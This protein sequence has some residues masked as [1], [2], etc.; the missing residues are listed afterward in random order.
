M[1]LSKFEYSENLDQI[2]AKPIPEDS[3]YELEREVKNCKKASYYDEN[4]D[5]KL[6]ITFPEFAKAF[7]VHESSTR[8]RVKRRP[9]RYLTLKTKALLPD[10]TTRKVTLL[11][12]E[13]IGPLIADLRYS[14]RHNK[15][16]LTKRISHAQKRFPSKVLVVT[17]TDGEEGKGPF[18]YV[19]DTQNT[20]S[21]LRVAKPYFGRE[22]DKTYSFNNRLSH[23]NHE[24]KYTVVTD[25]FSEFRYL[26]NWY[27]IDC[28]DSLLEY[29]DGSGF[30]PNN[31]SE[32]EER[33][34]DL[35]EI[36]YCFPM[37]AHMRS[38]CEIMKL[39]LKEPRKAI[40]SFWRFHDQHNPFDAKPSEDWEARLAEGGHTKESL[41]ELGFEGEALNGIYS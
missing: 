18:I 32:L 4:Q 26:D 37:S 31:L 33:V 3:I 29:L 6:G 30:R 25:L 7:G 28:L 14:P 24:D 5:L 39:Y 12:E 11:K 1:Q 10:G 20:N 41:L 15:K 27:S 34:E 2:I 17:F 16:G 13:C 21:K 35:T 38:I 40:E 19:T 22:I 23:T 8:A 9:E 36:G